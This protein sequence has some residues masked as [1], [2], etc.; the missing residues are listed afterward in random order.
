M[1]RR[2]E[3]F[4]SA[5]NAFSPRRTLFLRDE[6]FFSETN[7]SSPRKTLFLGDERFFSNTNAFSRRRTLLLREKRVFSATNAFS[8][9]KTLF[10]GDERFFLREKR[11]EP[12]HGERVAQLR[13][14]ASSD[15]VPSRP[16]SGSSRIASRHTRASP[17]RTALSTPT[18]SKSIPRTFR[19]SFSLQKSIPSTTSGFSG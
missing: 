14:F 4:F 5:K 10:L 15:Q 3:R 18:F 16:P 9:Q 8:P 6:R 19:R 7:A 1:R 17:S 11:D 13:V 12:V 2:Y